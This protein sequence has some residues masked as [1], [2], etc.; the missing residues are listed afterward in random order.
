MNEET[1]VVDDYIDIQSHPNRAA[2][3][4]LSDLYR[5]FSSS[6][7]PSFQPQSQARPLRNQG[8]AYAHVIHKLLFYASHTLSIPPMVFKSLADDL[9]SRAGAAQVGM[10][11]EETLY[12]TDHV[13]NNITSVPRGT[14]LGNAEAEVEGKEKKV[15]FDFEPHKPINTSVQIIF[16]PTNF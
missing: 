9:D 13:S 2:V 4:M 16:L 8:K 3:Y 14:G 1:V 11:A 7:P 6:T 10:D 5:L 12:V 15:S